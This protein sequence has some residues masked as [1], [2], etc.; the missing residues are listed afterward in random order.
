MAIAK[1]ILCDIQAEELNSNA[2]GSNI[3]V[4][5]AESRIA[6]YCISN[7]G[8]VQ[9]PSASQ[10]QQERATN[11]ALWELHT[12]FDSTTGRGSWTKTVLPST[13]S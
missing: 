6:A 5:E 8:T 1:S 2:F 12:I 4:G 10:S 11:G 7:N 13:S 9:P 3:G